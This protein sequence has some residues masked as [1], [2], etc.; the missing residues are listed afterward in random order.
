MLLPPSAKLDYRNV[1]LYLQKA[2]LIFCFLTDVFQRLCSKL[3]DISI[4]GKKYGLLLGECSLGE[5]LVMNEI[6]EVYVLTTQM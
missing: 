6:V 2:V 5:E 1:T 3:L 4:V